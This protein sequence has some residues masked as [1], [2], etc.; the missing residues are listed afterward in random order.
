MDKTDLTL[1]Y[2]NKKAD[3]FVDGT[4]DVDFSE[5]QNEFTLYIKKGGPYLRSGMRVWQRQQS[6]Y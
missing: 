1:E 4:R 3:S 2:Y 5:L 6:L